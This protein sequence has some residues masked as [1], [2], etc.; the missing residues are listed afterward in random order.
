MRWL[1]LLA[2]V[3]C[4]NPTDSVVYK[5]CTKGVCT[6]GTHVTTRNWCERVI[7]RHQLSDGSHA[8]CQEVE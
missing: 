1:L 6:V 8:V 4:N 5:V 2:L 3:G 7:A